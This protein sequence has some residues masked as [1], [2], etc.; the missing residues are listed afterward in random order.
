[1][2]VCGGLEQLFVMR[3]AVVVVLDCLIPQR[4]LLVYDL[5]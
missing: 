5:M 3:S 4:W 1:M 2:E